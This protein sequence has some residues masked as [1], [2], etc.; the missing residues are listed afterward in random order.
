LII[1]GIGVPWLKAAAGLPWSLAI[2]DGF[3]IFIVGGLIK[4]TAGGIASPV[5]WRAVRRRVGQGPPGS[6]PT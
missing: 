1:F 4:A 2:H 5:A 6:R 3:T